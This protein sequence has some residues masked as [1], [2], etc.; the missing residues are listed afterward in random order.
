M[1]YCEFGNLQNYLKQKRNN[2]VNK[3]DEFGNMKTDMATA[4]KTAGD[5]LVIQ[6]AT[7]TASITTDACQPISTK[8]LISWS[9][10]IARG[11]DYLSSK[12]VLQYCFRKT[13]IT[14]NLYFVQVLHGDLAA[15]N[16]LL[17]DKEVVKV[18]D[19]GMS[20]KMYYKR[21]FEKKEQVI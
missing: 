14:V 21:Y 18:S 9:F 6:Q 3:V 7:E 15:R 11:M 16:I 2:F 5:G 17:T 4:D 20:R 1:E 13:D 8:N 10:Q 12:K 19:F